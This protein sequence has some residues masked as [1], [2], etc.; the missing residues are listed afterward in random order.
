MLTS[1]GTR[2]LGLLTV[3]RLSNFV[4]S[5]KVTLISA[6]VI[7]DKSLRLIS[8]PLIVSPQSIDNFETKYFPSIRGKLLSSSSQ[9]KKTTSAGKPT[10]LEGNIQLPE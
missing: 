9:S 1:S 4:P 7:R 2:I 6:S 8:F 5:K 3:A 10:V